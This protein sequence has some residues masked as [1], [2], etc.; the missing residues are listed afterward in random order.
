[1]ALSYFATASPARLAV[2]SSCLPPR[3]A[4]QPDLSWIQEPTKNA[5]RRARP[6]EY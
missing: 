2:M 3:P 5:M 4:T 1:M 6:T